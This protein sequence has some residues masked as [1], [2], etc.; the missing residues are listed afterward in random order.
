MSHQDAM[1]ALTERFAEFEAAITKRGSKSS[2]PKNAPWDVSS[3][4][5]PMM[6]C[7]LSCKFR[8]TEAAV[9]L[10]MLLPDSPV[11]TQGH[12]LCALLRMVDSNPCY[13]PALHR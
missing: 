11:A 8:S 4:A 10:I 7:G 12:V 2:S 5:M 1:Q 13:A 6:T 3:T 9:M